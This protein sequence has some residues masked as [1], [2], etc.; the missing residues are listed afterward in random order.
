MSALIAVVLLAVLLPLAGA[1][2]GPVG[3]PDG[4]VRA[5]E[6]D[7]RG[8]APA[9][10]AGRPEGAAAE[11]A[12]G[13]QGD[14]DGKSAEPVRTGQEWGSEQA[15]PGL[16]AGLGLTTA[17]QC[18]PELASPEGVEA[19][20]CVLSQGQDTW[21]R[22]YYRNA[23]GE[24]LTSVLTLMG[25]D[26]RTV[27]MHCAVDEG[28]EPGA[29]ETP[30]ERTA[31]EREAYSAVAEFAAPAA[32]GEGTDGDQGEERPMLLRSGSNAAP[33]AAS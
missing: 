11:G 25:P 18:G 1:V 13:G 27:Q 3:P 20:T 9:P 29:C 2:A 32:D 8:K 7:V 30:R 21:A 17:A 19:Q 4:P 22:T 10:V 6:E 23:T 26:G 33:A 16:L 15:E 24:Q 28:D 12:E 14:T 31:G 5:L